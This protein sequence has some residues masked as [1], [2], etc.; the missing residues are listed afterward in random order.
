MPASGPSVSEGVSASVGAAASSL[1]RNASSHAGI[2]ACVNPAVQAAEPEW[3][4]WQLAAPDEFLSATRAFLPE[5]LLPSPA[6]SPHRPRPQPLDLPP[7]LAPPLIPRLFCL[8]AQPSA[9]SSGCSI[10]SGS[11]TSGWPQPLRHRLPPHRARARAANRVF[12]GVV[13]S[14]AAS[15]ECAGAGSALTQ[16]IG[17]PSS[18]GSSARGVC[19]RHSRR[20]DGGCR[21]VPSTNPGRLRPLRP[22]LPPRVERAST[23]CAGFFPQPIRH[24]LIVGSVAPPIACGAAPDSSRSHSGICFFRSACSASIS[25]VARRRAESQ[26]VAGLCGAVS[27]GFAALLQARQPPLLPPLLAPNPFN[28][29]GTPSSSGAPVAALQPI[30]PESQQ[31]FFSLQLAAPAS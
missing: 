26:S 6:F 3:P 12:R 30:Q 28:Q 16:P 5:R 25:G 1:G 18:V 10:S 8:P 20:A 13:T 17:Q 27:S 31:D 11:S 15:Q 22:E 24:F 19:G 14:S 4:S 2:S 29:S 9:V 21:R 23:G 7:R